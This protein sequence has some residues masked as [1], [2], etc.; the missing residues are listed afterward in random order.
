[1][2]PESAVVAACR[3]VTVTLPL[4]PRELSPNHTVGSRGGRFR[5]AG[6]TKQYRVVA[7]WAAVDA[8]VEHNFDHKRE[9]GPC[10]WPTATVQAT[11]YFKDKRRRDRD[12]L[13][14]SMK[15]AFDGLADAGLVTNDAGFTYLPVRVEVDKANPRVELVITKTDTTAGP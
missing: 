13:L 6:K 11:F 9:D 4:P 8:M 7:A 2:T 15:A 14:A 12:N 10:L 1:M 5:K 3:S